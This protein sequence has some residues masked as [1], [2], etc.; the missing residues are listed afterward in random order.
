NLWRW[1][2]LPGLNEG[3]MIVKNL[4]DHM[5]GNAVQIATGTKGNT[6]A[7]NEITASGKNGIIIS[8]EAQILKANKITASGMKPIV[9]QE[10]KHDITQ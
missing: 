10:G 4:F 7:Q 9:I 2:K 3:N 1:C 6:V 8:G 5:Q